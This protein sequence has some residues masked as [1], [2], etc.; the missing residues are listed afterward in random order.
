M[1]TNS[2]SIPIPTDL[3]IEVS[4]TMLD[5]IVRATNWFQKVY[6]E[7]APN[8]SPDYAFSTG[9]V[10][11]MRCLAQMWAAGD[12]NILEKGQGRYVLDSSSN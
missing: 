5:D 8:S 1:I 12:V 4:P 2:D 11:G 9:F 3:I 10:W 6:T 7:G